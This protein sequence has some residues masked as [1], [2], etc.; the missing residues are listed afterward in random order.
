MER[1]PLH[2][3]FVVLDRTRGCSLNHCHQ[4]ASWA[5]RI[6]SQKWGSQLGQLF[7]WGL[8][9]LWN[10]SFCRKSRRCA[11]SLYLIGARAHWSDLRGL[12]SRCKCRQ[13][14]WLRS[15][16]PQPLFLSYLCFQTKGRSSWIQKSQLNDRSWDTLVRT[17]IRWVCSLRRL[18]DRYAWECWLIWKPLSCQSQHH[19]TQTSSW[20]ASL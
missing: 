13:T 2:F 9:T 20:A 18:L 10:R 16:V 7:S 6:A 15:W 1:Q 17:T 3:R 14:S 5:T 4:R 12:R 11:L 19:Q 8:H